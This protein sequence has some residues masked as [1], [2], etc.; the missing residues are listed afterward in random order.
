MWDEIRGE[1]RVKARVKAM[2]L[3]PCPGP[4]DG[5]MPPSSFSTRQELN[6]YAQLCTSEACHF[7]LDIYN[8]QVQDRLVLDD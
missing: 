7:C 3:L 2:Q 5:K 4:E 1:R 6:V 8:L